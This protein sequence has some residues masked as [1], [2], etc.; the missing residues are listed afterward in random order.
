MER[1][2]EITVKGI[3]TYHVP[4]DFVTVTFTLDELNKDYQKGLEDFEKHIIALQETVEKLGF[5][6]K[7]LKTSAIQVNPKYDDVKRNG[8]YVE[9]FKGYSFYTKMNLAFVFDSKRLGSV[10]AT[11]GDLGFEPKLDVR[12]SVK[13]EESAK[14]ILLANAAKDA[15]TKS[16]VLCEA[17]GVR[18]G[19]L[20]TINYNWDE[21]VFYSETDYSARGRIMGA[22]PID[23]IPEDF[24]A[25]VQEIEDQGEDMGEEILFEYGYI[26]WYEAQKEG[27]KFT[28]GI[29][30]DTATFSTR[31]E[32]CQ[33]FFITIRGRTQ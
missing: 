30:S 19:K 2:R 16:K 18:L 20:V 8:D 14:N 4:V 22:R 5:E 25:F 29:E 33:N 15:K 28:K 17:M 24:A 21:I 10:F 13:D 32:V 12:F 31:T 6:K 9:V 27:E 26:P 1:N 3:G 7:E 11:V 23:F